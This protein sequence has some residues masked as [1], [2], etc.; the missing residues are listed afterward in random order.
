MQQKIFNLTIF[1]IIVQ[2]QMKNVNIIYKKY[3]KISIKI[4]NNQNKI[5]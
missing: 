5:K 1:N 4:R 3:N 2:S